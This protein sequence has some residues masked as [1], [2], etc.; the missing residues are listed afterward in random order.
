[1][2]SFTNKILEETSKSNAHDLWNQSNS[3][4]KDDFLDEYEIIEDLKNEYKKVFKKDISQG[5][6][7]EVQTKI[8]LVFKDNKNPEFTKYFENK[9]KSFVNEKLVQRINRT[10]KIDLKTIEKEL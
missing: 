1:M 6:F 9:F 3:N 7:E 5:S 10:R 8:E 4:Y 2:R